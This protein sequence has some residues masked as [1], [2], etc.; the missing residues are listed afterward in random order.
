MPKS[1]SPAY[2]FSGIFKKGL[3]TQTFFKPVPTQLHH[4][5]IQS[6]QKKPQ[7]KHTL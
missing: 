2:V 7:T 4:C 5:Y 6:V 1:D 3:D